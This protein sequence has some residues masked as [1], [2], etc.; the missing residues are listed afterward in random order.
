MFF[1]LG[2]RKG[3]P[4]AGGSGHACLFFFVCLSCVILPNGSGTI[5]RVQNGGEAPVVDADRAGRGDR[6]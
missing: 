4:W 5:H 3:T 1:P 2:K 6:G